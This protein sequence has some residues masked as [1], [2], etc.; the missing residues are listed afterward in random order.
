MN[1]NEINTVFGTFI[2]NK[3]YSDDGSIINCITYGINRKV[4]DDKNGFF[5]LRWSESIDEWVIFQY[6]LTE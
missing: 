1:K 4:I 6:V 3:I 5:N 2:G